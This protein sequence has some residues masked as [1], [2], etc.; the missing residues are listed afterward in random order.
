MDDLRV[1]PSIETSI[2][3]TICHLT[4]PPGFAW[5]YIPNPFFSIVFPTQLPVWCISHLYQFFGTPKR[6]IVWL[7]KYTYFI[8]VHIYIQSEYIYIPST[9]RFSLASA[10]AWKGTGRANTTCRVIEANATLAGQL[11]RQ[12]WLQVETWEHGGNSHSPNI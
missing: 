7:V 4:M 9:L 1:P 2:C 11:W 3:E 6:H 8:F 12:R 10:Q 5:T